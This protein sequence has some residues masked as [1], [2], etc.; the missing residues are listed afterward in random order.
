MRIHR[1]LCRLVVVQMLLHFKYVYMLDDHIVLWHHVDVDADANAMA[2]MML[3]LM[4]IRNDGNVN[5]RARNAIWLRLYF[6][7]C[8]THVM[9]IG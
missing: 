3:M 1:A 2:M 7:C 9:N 6:I 4:M 8:A 5:V